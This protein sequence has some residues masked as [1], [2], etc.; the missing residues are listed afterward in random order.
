MSRRQLDAADRILPSAPEAQAAAAAAA[1]QGAATSASSSAWQAA[2]KANVQAATA[3]SNLAAALAAEGWQEC[4]VL[5]RQW[6]CTIALCAASKA[7]KSSG[8][9]AAQAAQQEQTAGNR[10]AQAPPAIVLQYQTAGI[11][12]VSGVAAQSVKAQCWRLAFFCFAQSVLPKAEV[13]HSTNIV[14]LG[15]IHVM[16]VFCSTNARKVWQCPVNALCRLLQ[17]QRQQQ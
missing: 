3:S 11:N 1:V 10:Q 9:T 7:S 8:G 6:Q 13:Q 5:L 14:R 12:E 17:L 16:V 2:Q 4:H 15:T